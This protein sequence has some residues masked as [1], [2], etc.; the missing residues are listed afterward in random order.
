MKLSESSISISDADAEY[1]IATSKKLE[2]SHVA[3][4]VILWLIVASV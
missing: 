4:V 2:Q 1:L 3:H